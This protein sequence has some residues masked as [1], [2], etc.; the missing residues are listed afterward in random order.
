M[1]GGVSGEEFAGIIENSLG[2]RPFPEAFDP[3]VRQRA[4]RVAGEQGLLERI[5]RDLADERPI[6][7]IPHSRFRLFRS[8]GNR[9]VC[10]GQ[11]HDRARQID[12][13]AQAVFLGMTDKAKVL[14]D[15]LWAECE[16]TWWTMCSHENSAGSIDLRA[17][18]C[19][20]HYA[21]VVNLLS[22]DGEVA[23]RVLEE[24]RR[25]VLDEYLDP[26]RQHWWRNASHNWNAVCG[27]AVG[28]TA[29]LIEK[30]PARLT[31]ILQMVLGDLPTFLGGFADDGGCTEGAG[32]WRYGFGW[33]VL[34]AAGLH[35]FTNGAVNIM[36]GEKI[37]RICRYPLAVWV[38]PAVDLNFAD[39]H[40]GYLSATTAELINRFHAAPEL[41]GMC[42]R[43]D[44]GLL[45]VNTLMDLL[46]YDGQSHPPLEDRADY[47]LPDLAIVK[48]RTG[49]VTVG[50]KAGHN[51]EH[52]NHN[53]VGNFTV[54]RGAEGI[55]VDLGAPIYSRKTFSP[56]RYES[57]F[58]NS[59]GH[60]V[61][62]VNGRGQPSGRQ[63][64]GTLTAEGL[65]TAGD[66]VITIAMHGA[67]DEPRLTSL[68]RRLTVA[69]VIGGH[70]TGILVP[71]TARAGGGQSEAR[72]HSR[73]VSC[74]PITLADTFAFTESPESVEEVFIATCPVEAAGDGSAV[75][76]RTAAEGTARLAARTPGRFTVRELPEESA[77]SRHGEL[78]RRITFTPAELAREMTVR[79]KLTFE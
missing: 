61:P 18:M 73:P 15:L 34:L 74:P 64:A 27:G 50:A 77:E 23:V 38:A 1:F 41:Y 40:A 28:L 9:T 6:E 20:F 29:M 71:A 3:A 19:G 67:Y 59:F 48:V 47:L 43:T 30:D 69:G 14:Q 42:S 32:Y 26:T 25:R 72:R 54:H 63:Y 79:F 76:I 49:K 51:E 60:N 68:I 46:L 45:K 78:I 12:Q 11:M 5:A 31:R 44:A 56:Q 22:L 10:D 55:L 37:E 66:R 7:V 36:A 13:A 75:V 58:C 70:D 65:N 16:S 52:H 2:A 21:L 35:R 53:D 8:T 62:V 57:I 17:A 39:A 33:Y 24:I 4:I